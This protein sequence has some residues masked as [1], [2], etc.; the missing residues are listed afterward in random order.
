MANTPDHEDEQ[1]LSALAGRSDPAADSTRNL[2]AEALRRALKARAERL[3]AAVPAADAAQYQQL[4]FRLRRE[5]LLSAPPIWQ[6]P[7]M[8]GGAATVVLGV[9]VVIQ[10]AGLFQGPG[11]A[12]VMRG[13]KAG[14]LI[15]AEPEA[16]LAELLTGLRAAGEEP[17]VKREADGAVVLTVNSSAKVL[18]YLNSQR[19]EPP[20]SDGKIVLV[21]MR[22]KASPK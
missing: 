14:T 15:V 3:D 9:A 12:D 8:W 4:L 6:N 16:R 5:G 18:D 21:L 2:Q 7:K 20:V 22:A 19:I 10:S 1:W 11:D 17:V 13:S